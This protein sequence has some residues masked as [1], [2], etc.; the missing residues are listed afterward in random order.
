[1]TEQLPTHQP[2]YPPAAAA[3]KEHRK[4]PR[5]VGAIV[6]IPALATAFGAAAG[7][8]ANAAPTVSP[9]S[10]ATVAIASTAAA[11]ATRAW[12]REPAATG[13]ALLTTAAPAP[14]TAVAFT[15]AEQQPSSGQR[16]AT[17]SA[18]QYLEL[19]G[20]SRSGLIEQLEYEGYS[21]EDAAAAVDS[22]NVD[23]NEQAVRCAKQYLELTSFSRSGLIDQLVYEGFTHAQAEYGANAAY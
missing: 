8:K 20:F 1:M 10:Q 9:T 14:A 19:S 6:L 7:E 13:L 23:W 21:T 16:N 5:V 2:S 4:W 22:L 18:K 12:N 3:P 11:P 17:Q 15:P